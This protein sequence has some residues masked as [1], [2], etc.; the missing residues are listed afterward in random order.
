MA[1]IDKYVVLRATET[2]PFKSNT[3]AYIIG[4]MKYYSPQK[5][6]AYIKHPDGSFTEEP[7]T[8]RY[9][10]SLWAKY[11]DTMGPIQR[12]TVFGLINVIATETN[13]FV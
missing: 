4:N 10:D 12:K 8:N 3:I 1:D 2:T 5:K 13:G 11:V 6:R 7:C 9:Y